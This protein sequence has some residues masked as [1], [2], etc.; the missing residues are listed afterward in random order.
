ME[1]QERHECG[2][3][4]CPDFVKQVL[5]DSMCMVM[6]EALALLDLGVVSDPVEALEAGLQL[7]KSNTD[8]ISFSECE[9]SAGQIIH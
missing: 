9:S 8:R 6:T 5:F 3:P 4:D 2:N 1:Q 7:I